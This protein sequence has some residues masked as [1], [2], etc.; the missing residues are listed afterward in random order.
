MGNNVR[1]IVS[2]MEVDVELYTIARVIGLFST[3]INTLC[4]AKIILYKKL[5]YIFL[6]TYIYI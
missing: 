4:Q 3:N 6:Y 5:I 2:Q 1:Q